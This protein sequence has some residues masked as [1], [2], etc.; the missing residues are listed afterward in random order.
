VQ[1]FRHI[2]V[3]PSDFAIASEVLYHPTAMCTCSFNKYVF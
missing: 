2:L 3:S 1:V